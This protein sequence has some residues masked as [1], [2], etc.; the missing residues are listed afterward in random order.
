MF[1]AT[2]KLM[3]RE[4]GILTVYHRK[5]VVLI[6]SIL[7]VIVVAFI[8]I[9]ATSYLINPKNPRIGSF[10]L[11]PSIAPSPTR[12]P[13]PTIPQ[14]KLDELITE[15]ENMSVP[16]ELIQEIKDANSLPE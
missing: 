13:N 12:A 5:T 4:S 3:S 6:V 15:L 11:P 9:F 1:Y 7:A 10:E 16:P 8:L 2:L 14:E